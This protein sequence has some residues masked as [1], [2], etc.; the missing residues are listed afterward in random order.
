M[1]HI[2]VLL[3]AML[4]LISTQEV[5]GQEKQ[6]ARISSISHKEKET[7][8]ITVSS[9]RDFYV[10]NNVYMLYIGNSRYELSEQVNDGDGT[11]I[12]HFFLPVQDF[13]KAEN[14]TPM[15]LSY[16]ELEVPDGMTVEAL[17]RENFCPCWS[18]GKLNK[19]M[20]KP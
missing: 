8:V 5:K 12:I 7:V 2:I 20:L 19:K 3:I 17:C 4:S 9:K 13:E 11:G 16:G 1:K 14:G 6:K 10:G 18:L 15:Y